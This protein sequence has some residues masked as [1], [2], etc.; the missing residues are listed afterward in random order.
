MLMSKINIKFVRVGYLDRK[1]KGIYYITVVLNIFGFFGIFTFNY[2]W[3][4]FR[5]FRYSI[6]KLKNLICLSRLLWLLWFGFGYQTILVW[7]GFG[8]GSSY[9]KNFYPFRYLWVQ[10]NFLSQVQFDSR[11][12]VF[13]PT[14][15]FSFIF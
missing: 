13:C 3:I 7:V 4:L 2:F 5:Y 15:G 6:I 12:Q 11:I 14:I 9:T 1:S 10:Y 8:P